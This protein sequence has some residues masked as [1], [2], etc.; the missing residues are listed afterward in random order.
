MS[1][2]FSGLM[3]HA[4]IVLPEVAGS[5]GAECARTTRAMREVAA[6]AVASRPDRVVI[7]SPHSPRHR[8]LWSAWR[9]RHRGDLGRFRAPQLQVDLPDAAEV[10]DALGL[11]PVPHDAGAELDHGAMVP[12]A[13]L[14]QAGWRGPTAILARPWNAPEARA[15]GVELAALEGRTAVVASGDMSHRLKPGAPAGYDP[16]AQDFDDAF[17]AGLRAEDW[18]AALN[19]QPRERAAE[20]VI[21]STRVAM[22]A[23]GAPLNAEVLSYEGP[24]G[25]G[26]AEAVLADPAPPLYAVARKAIAAAVLGRDAPVPEGGEPTKGVFVTL[27][28]NGRLRGCIGRITPT[29]E[30]S[31]YDMIAQVAPLSAQHDPRFPAVSP[32]ELDEL[33]IEVSVL[34]PPEPVTDLATLDPRRYGV[35]VTSGW[36]RGVL[37]PDL[38]GVDTVEQQ[39]RITRRKAG[40]RGHEPVEVERFEVRKVSPP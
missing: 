5:R 17:V 38:E 6:R 11:V 31:L 30:R 37:L 24:F 9:G 7:I 3:C 13:F 1:T 39:L 4:P 28:K 12:L 18:D 15:V 19:A 14:W 16:R 20:D 25:V 36:R 34:E 10:A 2:C 21:E 40:I 23:A 22:Q 27:H 33:D 32:S 29:H 8:T 26:Y 35:V